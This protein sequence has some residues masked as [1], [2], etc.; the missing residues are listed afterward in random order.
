MFTTHNEVFFCFGFFAKRVFD[1]S[2]LAMLV[3][4]EGCA[5]TS[6]EETRLLRCSLPGLLQLSLTKLLLQLKMCFSKRLLHSPPSSFV[7]CGGELGG[8][9]GTFSSPNYPD[10]YPPNIL[11]H[12]H[13]Q[14]K[15]GMVIQLKIETLNVEASDLCFYDRLEIYEESD[16]F[17]LWDGS[18]R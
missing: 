12:W 17:S 3:E 15:M 10:S 7:V 14:V 2:S 13:I 6:L 16:S 4:D 11:C 9:K 18:T 8:P 5:F 1:L